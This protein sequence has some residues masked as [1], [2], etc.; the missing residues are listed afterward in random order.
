MLSTFER[1]ETSSD[2]SESETSEE[3]EIKYTRQ[4]HFLNMTKL[5]DYEKNRNML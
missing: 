5:E 3:E 4:T 2:E 1:V